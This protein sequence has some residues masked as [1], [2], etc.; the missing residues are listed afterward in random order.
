MRDRLGQGEDMQTATE[1]DRQYVPDRPVLR[2]GGRLVRCLRRPAGPGR[3]VAVRAPACGCGLTSGPGFPVV[4][5][6]SG[7]SDDPGGIRSLIPSAEL[8]GAATPPWTP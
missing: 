4:G 5:H 3:L 6:S 8:R 1:S 2:A 7:V